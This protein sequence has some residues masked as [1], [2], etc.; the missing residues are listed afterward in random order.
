MWLPCQQGANKLR[1]KMKPSEEEAE[2]PES[3]QKGVVVAD[4][5]TGN[6]FNTVSYCKQEKIR[7]AKLS[8]IPPNVVFTGKLSRYLTFT[9]LKQRHLIYE[10]C[11]IK[12][13]F[14]GK[15][16]GALENRK[17]LAQR[18]FPHLRYTI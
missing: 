13:I 7:W 3:V 9:T 15:L 8:R 5:V 16:R 11:I 18:I 14:T 12:L 1:E 2:I 10:A 4:Q 17:S 6:V